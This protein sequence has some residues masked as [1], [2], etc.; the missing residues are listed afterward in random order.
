MHF[1]TRLLP[2]RFVRTEQTTLFATAVKSDFVM[3]SEKQI[4]A[5]L[6]AALSSLRFSASYRMSIVECVFDAAQPS[7]SAV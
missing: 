5:S 2:V 1:V 7:I 6:A 4:V 3:P